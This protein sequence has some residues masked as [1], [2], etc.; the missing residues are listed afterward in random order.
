MFPMSNRLCAAIALMMTAA[1]VQAPANAADTEI[2]ALKAEITRLSERLSALE[3]SRK[4]MPPVATTADRTMA[5]EKA[6]AGI[7]VKADFRY[8]YEMIDK[9]GSPERNRNRI[10]ARVGL[11]GDVNDSVSAGVQLATGGDNPTSTNQTLDDGFSTKDFGVDLAYVKW[12]ANENTSVTAGKMK[13]PM[14]RAGGN[15]LVWDGDVNPEGLALAFSSG[16]F[17][18]NAAGLY[19]EERSSSDDSFILGGQAGFNSDMNGTSLK[20]GIGYYGYTNTRGNSPFYDG[21]ANGNTVDVD[22]NLLNDYKLLE[23]FAELGGELGDMPFSVFAD[24]VQNTEADQFDT[25]YAFGVKL[26]KAKNPGSWDAAWIYQDVEPDAVVAAFNDS[27]FGGGGTDVKGHIFKAKYSIAK[28]WT[29]GLTYFLN[30]INENLGTKTDY[31]RLQADMQF[32]F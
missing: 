10:R 14:H 25:G 29:A 20:A 26:G 1:L 6:P 5:K 17:F 13:N 2:Q 19:V 9:D 23:L 3:E 32:K 22:G 30:D 7:K 24:W 18:V 31:R 16:S 8:R 27:D 11:S 4:Q 15:G 12:S 21:S 28:N